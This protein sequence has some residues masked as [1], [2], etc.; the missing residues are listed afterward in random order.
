MGGAW[1]GRNAE[2]AHFSA[3]LLATEALC[4]MEV[5]LKLSFCGKDL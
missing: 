5:I 1:I 2:W 3:G 4:L